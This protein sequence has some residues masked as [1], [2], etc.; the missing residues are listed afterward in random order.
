MA[1]HV[2]VLALRA[3]KSVLTVAVTRSGRP[4]KSASVPV[5]DKLWA[6]LTC[7]TDRH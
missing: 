2:A 6:K 7:R 1:E 5:I 3:G 4:S